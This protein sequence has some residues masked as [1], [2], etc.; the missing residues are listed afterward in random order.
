MSKETSLNSAEL[1]LNINFGLSTEYKFSVHFLFISC[2]ARAQYQSWTW[3][4]F[5]ERKKKKVM[6]LLHSWNSILTVDWESLLYW[7]YLLI[8]L[9]VFD[10]GGEY[11]GYVA[12]ITCSF[13]VNGK[14][15][16]EQRLIYE[17]VLDSNR[18]VMKTAKP[19]KWSFY[20]WCW[21]SSG[22]RP[23][24]MSFEDIP[25]TLTSLCCLSTWH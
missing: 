21:V 12:D 24:Q 15:T 13:P 20:S 8:L 16:P 9:S 4:F 23:M 7:N 5:S 18:T 2:L 11:Y 10:L 17:A 1:S 6:T 25:V 19:G 3:W 14:F 22:A